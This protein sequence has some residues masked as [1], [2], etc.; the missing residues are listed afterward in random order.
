MLL[1]VFLYKGWMSPIKWPS[2]WCSWSS[3]IRGS[4]IIRV[5]VSNFWKNVKKPGLWFARPR[6]P[7]LSS[8][9]NAKSTRL[10]LLRLET[11][12]RRSSKP[13]KT[14]TTL[15]EVWVRALFPCL[16]RGSS[17][18]SPSSPTF[19]RDLNTILDITDRL[20][21]SELDWTIVQDNKVD[22]M[23]SDHVPEHD[24]LD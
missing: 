5:N 9:K 11:R 14:A 4:L 17:F 21:L 15:R 12:P 16:Q 22:V 8:S 20:E 13:P 23:I 19:S 7:S 3:G 24:D 1:K 6:M 18:F 2:L 10:R